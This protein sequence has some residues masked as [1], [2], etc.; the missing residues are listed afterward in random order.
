VRGELRVE[1]KT[2]QLNTAGE[3]RSP[4]ARGALGV[5]LP[6]EPPQHT[7]HT[8][9]ASF[10]STAEH[11]SDATSQCT[12]ES[13]FNMTPPLCYANPDD[14]PSTHHLPLILIMHRPGSQHAK[15]T[16]AKPLVYP[17]IC[18]TSMCHSV[19][20]RVGRGMPA[21]TPLGHPKRSC[22]VLHTG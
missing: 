4:S 17:V 7:S 16:Y 19:L 11:S 10:Y 13:L 8:A 12:K 15:H 20:S 6:Q 9:T 18:N 5:E 14:C 2:C 1:M 3:S 22:N 21:I